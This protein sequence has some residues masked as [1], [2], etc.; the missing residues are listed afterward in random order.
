[1]STKDDTYTLPS[2]ETV[3]LPAGTM[4]HPVQWS[5][6]RDSSLYPS[7]ETFLPDRWLLPQWPT[8]YRE[9][10]STYPNLQNFSAFGFGRRICPGQNIAERS[11]Y[12]QIA[13]VAWSCELGKKIDEAGTPITPPEWDY[14][15]GFNVQPK[16]FPFDLKERQGRGEVV[17]REWERVWG[18]RIRGNTEN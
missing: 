2:G 3:F 15:A 13:R 9:P 5:I 17:R 18:E 7:P 1:M 11:L 16:W 12:I 8:T 10:L 6:H 14:V 4:V